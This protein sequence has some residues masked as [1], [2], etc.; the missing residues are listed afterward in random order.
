[1]KK[2]IILSS[3]SG[4]ILVLMGG[5]FS[6]AHADL[7]INQVDSSNI[8]GEANVELHNSPY[9]IKG[10]TEELNNVQKVVMGDNVK[11]DASINNQLQTKSISTD[12]TKEKLVNV[13]KQN[14]SAKEYDNKNDKINDKI[15]DTINENNVKISKEELSKKIT[16]SVNTKVT[17]PTIVPRVEQ[18]AVLMDKGFLSNSLRQELQKK[19]WSLE[20]ASGSDRSI[21]VSYTLTYKDVTDLVTQ[22]SKLYNMKIDVYTINKTIYVQD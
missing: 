22:I 16:E 7:Y 20:W 9:E 12:L 15:N 19:G 4:S 10:R 18:S 1:M 11:K 2:K 14:N 3:I 6:V 21:D 13:E 17:A 5:F 8:K